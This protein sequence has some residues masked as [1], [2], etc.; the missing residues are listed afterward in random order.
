MSRSGDECDGVDLVK[1]QTDTLKQVGKAIKNFKKAPEDRRSK[2]HFDGRLARLHRQQED[3]Y[4]THQII[5]QSDLDLKDKYYTEEIYNQFEEELMNAVAFITEAYNVKFPSTTQAQADESLDTSFSTAT[6]SNTAVKLPKLAVPPFSGDYT[7]WPSFFDVYQRLIHANTALAPCEK[8]IYLKQA[9]PLNFDSD[10]RDLPTTNENY[11]IAWNAIIDRYSNERVLFSHYMNKLSSQT[12]ITAERA[13]AIKSLNDTSRACI[14]ALKQLKM[15]TSKCD[16]ILVH[17]LVL[18]LPTETHTLWQQE[19][20]VSKGI[21]T[22]KKFSDFLDIRYRVL[23]AIEYKATLEMDDKSTASSQLNSRTERSNKHS[24]RAH[25]HKIHHVSTA[26]DNKSVKCSLCSQ[27]HIL[28]R[29][30]KFLEFDCFDRKKHVDKA[31]HCTN[32]L[33]SIHLVAACTS[34][35]NCSV[36][37][38]RHHTLLHFPNRT[39]NDSSTYNQQNPTTSS[40]APAVHTHHVQ[41]TN[42]P[43]LAKSVKFTSQFLVLLPTAVVKI[44]TADGQSYLLRALI[45]QGSTG[46][47]ISERAV[48]SLNLRRLPIFSAIKLTNSQRTSGHGVVSL[49]IR[50]RIDQNYQIETTASVVKSVTDDLPSKTIHFHD[51]PHLKG[52]ELADPDFYR[53]APIDL[54]IG[55]DVHASILMEGL[56]KGEPDEPIAQ[57]TAL[58]WIVSGSNATNAMT[59]S[60]TI[61]MVSNHVSFAQLDSLVKRFYALETVPSE[62]QLTSE[63]KWCKEYFEKTHIRQE[64]GKYRVRLPLKSLFN[65]DLGL[66]KSHQMALNRFHS[67][68]RKRNNNFQ[69]KEQYTKSI[70]EYFELN[71][72][73]PVDTAESRHVQHNGSGKPM[74]RC[75]TLPHHAVIR[76]DHITTKCRVVF[77]ASAKTSN[78]TSL[79]DLLCVGPPLLNDLASVLMNWRLHKYVITSDVEKMYRCIDIDEKDSYYQKIL[80]Y[81][82]A[83]QLS[84]FRLTTVTFGT[85]SATYT[86]V[87][88]MHKLADDEYARYPLATNVLKNE[89]YMDDIYTGSDSIESTLKIRDDTINALQSAGFK[90]HKWASN[91]HELLASIPME[92]HGDDNTLVLSNHETIKTLGMHWQPNFDCFCYKVNFDI[93]ADH[94]LTTKRTVLSTIAKLFDPLGLINPIVV[95]AK[96]FMKRLWSFNLNWDDQLPIELHNEWTQILSSLS[97]ISKIQIPRWVYFSPGVCKMVELHIFCDGSSHAYAALAYVRVQDANGQFRVSLI[98]AKSK[99][100][101]KPPITIPRIE[102][103][104]AVLGLKLSQWVL[105]QLSIASNITKTYYWLDATIVLSWIRGNINKWPI[106]VANRIGMI[107]AATNINQWHHV[108]TNENPADFSSRGLTPQQIIGLDAYWYGPKWLM[109]KQVNWPRSD[110]TFLENEECEEIVNSITSLSE[111]SFIRNYSTFGRLLQVTAWILRFISNCKK[112]ACE[113]QFEILTAAEINYALLALAKIVQTECFASDIH[114]VRRNLGVSKTLVSLSPFLDAHDLLRV[115]GRL[116]NSNLS[117]NQKHPIILPKH[118]HLTDLIIKDAHLNTLHGGAQLT[119]NVIRKRFW[120]IHAR[121][122]VQNKIRKCVKCFKERPQATQQLMGN[123]PVAR[124]TSYSRPF[125]ATGV[126]F[127]GAIELKASR[128]RGNTTYKGYIAVFICL[129]TK[130]VHLEAVTGMSAEQ[131]LCALYRFFGRRGLCHDMYSDNGTNFVGADRI[132]RTKNKEFIASMNSDVVPKL[133][134]KGVQWHF[135]PPHSPNFGGIWEANV[136]SVK[137]HLKRI[138]TGSPMTYED[139]ATVLAQIEGCLNSRPLCPLTSDTDDLAILTPGHFLIGDAILA[140]PEP[141]IVDKSPTKQYLKLQRMVQQF[142]RKWSADWLSHLQSRPKWHAAKENLKLDDV[143]IIKNDQLPPNQWQIGKIIAV[144]P[145]DDQLVRV[146]TVQTSTGDYK[147][148]VSKICRLPIDEKQTI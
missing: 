45:D 84:E 83:N 28:R 91:A 13:S 24:A 76:N 20:G 121:K 140:P 43:N 125:S 61:T 1:I 33:S 18:K 139:L 105:K 7:D 73:I 145:G 35:K 30:S 107:H 70:N 109:D 108:S 22:F 122:I 88:T 86:A 6:A 101:P 104:A 19:L 114:K 90:L 141:P 25:N 27:P 142:W 59:G 36:C 52:L 131:F 66:G 106:F 57:K 117:F 42:L 79:N 77:D 17:F 133:A 113:R 89:I 111:E 68:E 3:F 26:T 60:N 21:P 11:A 75:C 100:T 112:P 97:A 55:A 53:S 96:I 8:F 31:R 4:K 29:C 9:L 12:A 63:E 65:D 16:P 34:T 58:G 116:Q 99:V 87:Q 132:I 47:L 23:E 14:N 62:H 37:G 130:A 10:V 143:V 74:Y 134:R 128:Y 41:K 127:T 54:L 120:I 147:R 80:W 49:D 137:H 92:Q 148:C 71:Q 85:A 144:H 50:S 126:D 136:K 124:I 146:V 78:G 93:E 44:V 5:L 72:L 64:N 102:L 2:S 82:A 32:C 51:W 135:N 123:L 110:W 103:C 129:A 138:T 94:E 56:I 15:D 39:S 118:H 48:Q 38:K 115:R 119:L 67:A 46:T 40:N 69:L 98:A 81:D 95:T